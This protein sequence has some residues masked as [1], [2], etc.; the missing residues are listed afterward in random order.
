MQNRRRR[1]VLW[2]LAILVLSFAGTDYY[3]RGQLYYTKRV[4]NF[5]YLHTWQTLFP[6]PAP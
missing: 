5:I 3:L 1:V 4:A 6:R 2:V